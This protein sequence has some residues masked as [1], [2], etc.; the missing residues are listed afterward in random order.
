[1]PQLVLPQL[2][3]SQGFARLTAAFAIDDV[4]YSGEVPATSGVALKDT[5]PREIA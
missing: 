2:D 5:A 1:M 3:K 4:V